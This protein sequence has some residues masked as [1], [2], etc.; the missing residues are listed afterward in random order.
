MMFPR[1]IPEINRNKYRQNHDND[2]AGGREQML[3][4]PKEIDAVEES[5]EQWRIA[6]RCQ[7]APDIGHQEDCEYQHMRAV[8]AMKVRLNQGAYGDHGS[9][10]GADKARQRGSEEKHAGVA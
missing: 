5:N 3:R 4:R 6:E 2:E 9:A 7:R 8:S 1:V 10:S